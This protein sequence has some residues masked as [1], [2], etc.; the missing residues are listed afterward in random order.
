VTGRSDPQNDGSDADDDGACDACGAARCSDQ[1]MCKA[2][3]TGAVCACDPP[4]SGDDCSADADACA[5]ADV[6]DDNP[7]NT[8][9]L[10]ATCS[11]S[12]APAAT[13]RC[14]CGAGHAFDGITCVAA[15]GFV[16][17]EVSAMMPTLAAGPEFGTGTSAIVGPGVEFSTRNEPGYAGVD[18]DIAGDSFTFSLVN[19]NPD[20]AFNQGLLRIE[21]TDLHSLED[22]QSEITAVT[23]T[24]STFPDGTFDAVSFGPHSITL[25]VSEPNLLVPLLTTWS[26]T[27]AVEMQ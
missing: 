23:L 2:S 13:Y 17:D 15:S 14:T 16:G 9:D 25:D 3:S 24:S 5:V 22:R 11:D 21:I 26:A 20:G 27:F 4:W 12:V 10:A 6:A 19:D 8:E 18:L 1:G 7:C